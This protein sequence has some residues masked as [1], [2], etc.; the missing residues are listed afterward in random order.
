MNLSALKRRK[1]NETGGESS[2]KSLAV[3]VNLLKE[4]AREENRNNYNNNNNM[5]NTNNNE[6]SIQQQSKNVKKVKKSNLRDLELDLK[7]QSPDADNQY[8]YRKTEDTQQEGGIF[9]DLANLK[10]QKSQKNNEFKTKVMSRMRLCTLNEEQR[11]A[12]REIGNGLE[13]IL[14]TREGTQSLKR[15]EANH[16]DFANIQNLESELLRNVNHIRKKRSIPEIENQQSRAHREHTAEDMFDILTRFTSEFREEKP[17]QE[18]RSNQ[19]DMLKVVTLSSRKVDFLRTLESRISILQKDEVPRP[20]LHTKLPVAKILNFQKK[21][22][23][24]NAKRVKTKMREERVPQK[25]MRAR[26]KSKRGQVH[27]VKKGNENFGRNMV[28]DLAGLKK[29]TKRKKKKNWDLKMLKLKQFAQNNVF[30]INKLNLENLDENPVKSRNKNEKVRL[31]WNGGKSAKRD[32]KKV[33]IVLSRPKTP[34]KQQNLRQNRKRKSS[35]RSVKS[36]RKRIHSQP[37]HDK[38][39]PRQNPKRASRVVSSHFATQNE[40]VRKKRTKTLTI[41]TRREE[42]PSCRTSM[43]PLNSKVRVKSYKKRVKERLEMK[44]ATRS[45]KRSSSGKNRK[46]EIKTAKLIKQKLRQNSQKLRS[47][48]RK[49]QQEK[50]VWESKEEGIRDPKFTRS[51][52]LYDNL[53]KDIKKLNVRVRF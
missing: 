15:S 51:K 45:K 32:P 29:D 31:V 47:K 25:V 44:T 6:I 50:R 23:I 9:R 14:E 37:K 24:E 53:Q 8:T 49:T 28:R 20:K 21:K 36:R 30:E 33:K 10:T 42:T 39:E 46:F 35:R 38:S 19:N 26:R 3:I 27:V 18:I 41:K 4:K 40:N 2:D 1:A 43:S 12:E 5:N 48:R 52:M 11:G 22:R 7:Q 17:E 16:V 13:K 34:S